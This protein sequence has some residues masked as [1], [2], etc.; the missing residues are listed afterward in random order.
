MAALKKVFQQVALA[1]AVSVTSVGAMAANP[2]QV[3]LGSSQGDFDVLLN[4]QDNII[5][6]N[7]SDMVLASFIEANGDYLGAQNVCVGRAGTGDYRITATSEGGYVMSA[8]DGS[9][10]S[11]ATTINYEVRFDDV[12][13]GVTGFDG[14]NVLLNGVQYPTNFTTNLT[15]VQCNDGSAPPNSTIWVRAVGTDI[16]AAQPGEYRDTVTVTVAVN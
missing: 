12:V 2:G 15:D 6:N 11:L 16:D 3:G 13:D 1:A 7:L 5:I 9:G 10:G 14:G 4:K 8:D